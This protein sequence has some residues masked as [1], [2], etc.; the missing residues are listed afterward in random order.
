MDI[1]KTKELIKNNIKWE[2]VYPSTQPGGQSINIVRSPIQRL[3]SEELDLTIEFG[4]YH[5][6][7]RNREM[8]YNLFELMLD[9]LIK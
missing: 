4:Y 5:S 1:E 8:I 9:D 6:V 3:R 7:L 2:N